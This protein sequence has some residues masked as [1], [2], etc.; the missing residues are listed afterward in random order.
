MKSLVINGVTH[1]VDAPDDMPLLWVLRDI[2]GM[3]GTKYGCGI[4]QCGACT[5][6][7]DGMAVRACQTTMDMI[8]GQK[9]T[10][11]EGVGETEI[12]A[13]V[14]AAWLDK[15]VVQCGY[16]QSGQIMSA[17]S[18]LTVNPKPTDAEIDEAMAGNICRCAT[19]V[20]IREAIHSASA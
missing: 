3:T 9:I 10:T 15:E 5:V 11:I 2:L 12:G 7:V 16:C 13:K 20:R 8:D 4:A 19:Y 1:Q 17:T 6:H 14:Q 18:L